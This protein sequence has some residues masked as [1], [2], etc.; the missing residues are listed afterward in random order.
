MNALGFAPM[1]QS[2]MRV[3][4]VDDRGERVLLA[5]E[6]MWEAGRQWKASLPPFR[7]RRLPRIV[8]KMLIT[9][10]GLAF[11]GSCMI[12]AV[13]AR[14]TY[15]GKFMGFGLLIFTPVFVPLLTLGLTVWRGV[16]GFR[17]GLPEK[18]RRAML[19]RS[20]CPSCCYD[21]RGSCAGADGF[22]V[23]P[24]CGAAWDAGE[25]GDG[26]RRGAEVVVIESYQP[27]E[28]A[29]EEER[30]RDDPNSTQHTSNSTYSSK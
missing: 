20:K 5:N 27:T 4:G 25:I 18:M 23:C 24:E 29:R 26:A 3:R 15:D 17:G 16:L 22:A 11:V 9:G 7:W 14:L 10:P 2:S 28:R 12:V 6:G 19:A 8:G 30:V 21:L 13:L 1:I